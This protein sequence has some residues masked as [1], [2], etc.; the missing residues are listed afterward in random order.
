VDRENK[1]CERRGCEVRIGGKVYV[2]EMLTAAREFE[3]SV[4]V[5]G[6]SPESLPVGCSGT[7]DGFSSDSLKSKLAREKA[8]RD[9]EVQKMRSKARSKDRRINGG[10]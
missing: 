1:L 2:F 9:A 5:K 4:L 7:V 8:I 6:A 3:R 10:H